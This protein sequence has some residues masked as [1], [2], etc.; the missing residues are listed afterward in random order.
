MIDLRAK[1]FN[2]NDDQCA[3]VERTLS[4]MTVEEKTAQLFFIAG[5]GD[6]EQILDTYRSIPF[7][8]VMYRPNEAE[9]IR[10]CNETLQRQ[11]KIPLLV[12]ANLE[13]GGAG[14]A[15]DGTFYGSQM[16]VAATGDPENAR[17]LGSISAAEAAAVGANLAFAP[18]VDIDMN[19]RN[20]ITNVRTYGENPEKVRDFASA[21][22]RGA[23][24]HNVAVSIKHF[25][26]DGVDERDQHILPSV[27]SLSCEDWDRTY[28]MVYKSLIEQGAQTVMVG[29]IMQPAYSM[30]LNPSLTPKDIFPATLSHEL[31]TGLLR[32]QLGFNGVVIT[33]AANMVG[34]SCMMERRHQVAACVNAGCDLFLFGRNLMEDYGY[35][36]DAVKDG[37]INSQRLDEAVTRILA[38][39]ASLGL[40]ERAK[41]VS[42][43]A[44]D[45][46]GCP[47]HQKLAETCADQS[48][49]LVKDTQGL[50]PV[51][52]ERYRRVWLH[53]L[54]EPGFTDQS[55]C[56]QMV[57]EEL[58]KA[59]F[60]V[61]YDDPESKTME[62]TQT[63]VR[64]LKERYD[65]IMYFANI[66][67]A[68]YKTVTRLKWDSPAA[69]NAPYFTSDIPTLFVSLANP[70]HFADVP[71]IRTI[72]NAYS[73]TRPVVQAVIRKMMGI[74]D[75]R[76]VNPVDPFCGLWGKDY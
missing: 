10:Q 50:L 30:K 37:T 46:V 23:A 35:M 15:L 14:I 45:I 57:I 70:R 47:A 6:E 20:P 33:D 2:L 60:E 59:G 8:G 25:P 39:K 48:V 28:G 64:D 32:G 21:Y 55:T 73:P 40:N 58:T 36:L 75:F 51:S 5:F 18:V 44:R 56:A 61:H 54:D 68:S 71:M 53:I 76:G 42:G 24:E 19:W 74:G 3:W 31:I 26:G 69:I 29:H 16:Q 49:T 52:P 65:I 9:I 13:S 67:N 1:P 17:H 66:V 72:I 62:D 43:T 41:T 11:V 27:N 22:L 4:E 34:M 38:L 7:G 63:A 12:A